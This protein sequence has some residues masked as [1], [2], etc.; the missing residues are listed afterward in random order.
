MNC[1]S[2][3]HPH[4]FDLAV[5]ACVLAV[6]LVALFYAVLAFAVALGAFC[7]ESTTSD[8]HARVLLSVVL[9]ILGTSGL[10]TL[11][12]F[13]NA[14]RGPRTAEVSEEDSR[15]VFDYGWRSRAKTLADGVMSR[16]R[17]RTPVK[18]EEHADEEA[19]SQSA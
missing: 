5:T 7:I 15:D 2:N 3:P 13:W 8:I 6:P 17:R 1:G 9:G 12:F 14:W 16:I 19:K 4:D 11:L 10:A 18:D